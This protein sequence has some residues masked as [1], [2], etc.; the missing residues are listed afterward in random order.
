MGTSKQYLN[1]KK[2][3]NIFKKYKNNWLIE[4]FLFS[5][6]NFHSLQINLIE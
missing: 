6:L 4:Y 3:K 1:S 5:F 2:D